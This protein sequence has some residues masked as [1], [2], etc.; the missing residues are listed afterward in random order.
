VH[1]PAQ[2]VAQQL[3]PGGEGRWCPWRGQGWRVG[4]QVEERA[5]GR[6][7]GH[8]V[9]DGMVHLHDQADPPLCQAWQEPHLPQR[10]GPVQPPL[11]Q[12]LAGRQQ[13]G[14]ASGR[15]QRE[16]PDMAGDVEGGSVDPQRPAQPPPRGVQQLAE[17]GQ[18]VKPA[19]DPLTD[20]LDR[21]T[22][23]RLGQ[24]R[25]VED[26]ERPDVLAPAEILRQHH[27]QILRTQAFHSASPTLRTNGGR[28]D[29]LPQRDR[30]KCH[31]SLLVPCP[32]GQ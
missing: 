32:G 16:H 28:D 12:L 30:P 21:E 20:G 5:E 29:A 19:A 13:L 22:A 7:P 1:P 24:P 25:A 27:A 23:P 3:A 26:D 4:A 10:A 14:L 2:V 8:A 17:P 6:Y 31:P 18:Q 11:P 9:G 15:G